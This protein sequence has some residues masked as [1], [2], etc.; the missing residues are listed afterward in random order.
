MREMG[1]LGFI[2]PSCRSS[3]AAWGWVAAGVI[4]EEIA[5]AD[6]SF[7]YREP[8]GFAEQPDPV[9]TAAGGGHALAAENHRGR[10]ICAIA[11][12]RATR[13]IGRGQ[14]AAAK[15]ERVGDEYV[16][17]GEDLHLGRRPG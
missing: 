12:D 15:I 3:S 2:C 7:S 5:R 9:R 10:G 1:E 13:R 8:A 4:H 17:N 6:L 14:P 11:P 16:I